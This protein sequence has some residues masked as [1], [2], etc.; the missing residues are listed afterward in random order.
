MTLQFEIPMPL[1]TVERK[2][3]LVFLWPE[4]VK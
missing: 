4:S 3:S 2:D 1:N